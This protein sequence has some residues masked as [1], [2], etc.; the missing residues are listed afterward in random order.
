MKRLERSQSE[1]PSRKRVSAAEGNRSD[2]PAIAL[3]ILDLYRTVCQLQEH[4]QQGCQ[5]E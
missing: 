2:T 4:V 3:D 5:T 1:V